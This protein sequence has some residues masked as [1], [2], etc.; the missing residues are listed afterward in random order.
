[1]TGVAHYRELLASIFRDRPWIV[2]EDVLIACGREARALADLGASSVFCLAAT[3]GTGDPP[4][5]ERF[6]QLVLGIEAVDIMSSIRAAET[7]LG[8]LSPEVLARL[9][10]FDPAREARVIPGITAGSEVIA[11]RP[12]F[13]ARPAA[14]RALEDKTI[15]DEVWDG[16]GVRRAPRRIVAARRVELERAAVD[17]DEG[18]GTIWVG[19]NREGF[20]GGAQYLRWVRAADDAGEAVEFLE[21]HCDS[22]RVM[23]FLDGIPCSIH[24]IVFPDAQIAFRPCEMIVFRVPGSN[25]LVYAQA[26]TGWDPD[27]ADREEMRGVARHVGAHLRETVGYRGSFSVDGVLSAQGFL[28][29]ELNPRYG[30]ALGILAAGLPELPIY[31]LHLAIAEG[32]EFDWRPDDLEELIVESADAHRHCG[33]M[34]V[35]EKK[36]EEQLEASLVEESDGTWRLAGGG[37]EIDATFALG[38]NPIGCF[39][40]LSFLP[41]RIPIGP[42]SAPRVAAAFRFIDAQW[43]LGIGELEPARDVRGTD[44]GCAEPLPIHPL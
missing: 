28:P 26:S 15:I 2:A 30:A 11:G 3:R 44:A 9:D 10:T 41:E 39:A 20:H 33:S 32:G 40:H 1:M 27:P 14:W 34:R 16:A 18:L 29:T 22:V 6:D 17:L 19:D 7:A 12:V 4:D 35:L 43:E 31:L 21:A 25:R 38:P 36:V 13:G 42:S 8:N 23:P 24:G 5:R 37:E